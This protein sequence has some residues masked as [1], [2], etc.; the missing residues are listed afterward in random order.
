M[1]HHYSNWEEKW[2]LVGKACAA[3]A[4]EVKREILRQVE[5]ELKE[6]I[7]KRNRTFGL[8]L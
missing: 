4:S 3:K 6:L 8:C 5:E 7:G 2:A 1:R